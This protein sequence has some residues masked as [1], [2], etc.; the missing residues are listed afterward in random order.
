MCV[1]AEHGLGGS[2][3]YRKVPMD[4]EG[5]TAGIMPA[6]LRDTPEVEPFHWPQP[7]NCQYVADSAV[8]HQHQHL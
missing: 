1:I 3:P 5:V 7:H 8:R 6:V 2:A 4:T